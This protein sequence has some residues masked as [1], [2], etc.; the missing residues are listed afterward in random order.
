MPTTSLSESNMGPPES[1]GTA[2]ALVSMR[3]DRSSVL[4]HGESD[5]TVS[6]WSVPVTLP[7]A[8][9]SSPP[10]SAL[11]TAATCVP[12]EGVS[13]SVFTVVRPLASFSWSS[14]TSRVW[15]KPSTV[16]E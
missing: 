3:P 1:P 12:I 15:S 9:T 5:E 2:R 7:A 4:P 14:A 6:A 8:F 16:A 10:P 11:P 13:V